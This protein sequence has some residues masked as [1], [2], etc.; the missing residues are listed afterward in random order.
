MQTHSD[1]DPQPVSSQVI[2][3]MQLEPGKPARPTLT[4]FPVITPKSRFVELNYSLPPLQPATL[5]PEPDPDSTSDSD[6]EDDET[7][8]ISSKLHPK[9]H[10]LVGPRAAFESAALVALTALLILTKTV[11][12]L[13]SREILKLKLWEWA[14]MLLVI[15]SGR[16]VSNWIVWITVFF[17]EKNFP[18]KERVLYFAYGLRRSVRSCIWFSLVLLAWTLLFDRE[19]IQESPAIKKVSRA[20][21]AVS[22]AAAIWL[23]KIAFVKVLASSFHVA[24]YFDRMKE[25]VFHHYILET[26]SG[27]PIEEEGHVEGPIARRVSRAR[28][29]PARLASRKIDIERLR[30]LSKARAGLCS[31][32]RMVGQVMRTGLTTVSRTVDRASERFGEAEAEIASEWEARSAA[33][34]VFKNVARP[35]NK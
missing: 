23:I 33:E 19:R 10:R 20:L 1:P 18:L 32:K 27:D 12:S 28:S 34:R 4:R 29:M 30:R 26:L 17:I 25:S 24:T 16:L 7:Q 6:I 9:A 3:D 15:F 13:K 14:V 11:P 8:P 5:K 21:I 35:G 22:I 31:V 2:L